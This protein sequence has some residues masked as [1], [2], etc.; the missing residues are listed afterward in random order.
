MA[1][2]RSTR[3]G[4]LSHLDGESVNILYSDALILNAAKAAHAA[5][6][7]YCKSI[8]DDT[9]K[10]WG[11][12]PDWQKE[13]AIAGVRFHIAN[14]DASDDA[15]HNSWMEQK[16]A[17]GWV[18]GEVKDADAK[19]HPCMVPFE[20]LPAEQQAKDALF[21]KTVWEVLIADAE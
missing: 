6:K 4:G 3:S 17:D 19:T 1:K 8:G 21:R 13:S 14:P 7:K 10:A 15:S 18:F 16:V 12:S 5:N 11:G 2:V 9:Q 20:D